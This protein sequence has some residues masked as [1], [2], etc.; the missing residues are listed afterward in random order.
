[1]EHGIVACGVNCI[2]CYIGSFEKKVPSRSC[3]LTL[4]LIRKS[5]SYPDSDTHL[6]ISHTLHYISTYIVHVQVHGTCCN[7]A[8]C[9]YII[10]HYLNTLVENSMSLSLAIR[11]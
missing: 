6:H 7:Y 10:V 9:M 1:M 11:T 4:F 8:Y 5:I 2:M 3:P